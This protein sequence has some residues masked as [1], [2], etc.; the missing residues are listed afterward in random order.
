MRILHNHR[1][2]SQ[3]PCSLYIVVTSSSSHVSCRQPV[4]GTAGVN[5]NDLGV[6]VW[7]YVGL[8]N[9]LFYRCWSQVQSDSFHFIGFCDAEHTP[10]FAVLSLSLDWYLVCV[11]LLDA[12]YLRH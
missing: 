5:A 1:L 2:L 6:Y 10:V 4:I 7:N 8:D 11:Y 3:P 12:F 9:I